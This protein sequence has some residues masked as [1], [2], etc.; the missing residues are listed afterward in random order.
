M[1]PFDINF[2]R[3]Q[4]WRSGI[5]VACACACACVCVCPYVWMSQPR[6]CP[7]ENFSPVQARINIFGPEVQNNCLRKSLT[8][9]FKVK[10]NLKVRTSL[11]LFPPLE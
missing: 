5:V 3:G 6:A 8:L 7:R 4:F 11:C 2:T 9:T 1:R 10:F